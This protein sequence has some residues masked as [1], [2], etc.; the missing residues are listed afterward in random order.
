MKPETTWR[1][2]R[3]DRAADFG[4]CRAAIEAA[5]VPLLGV[6][7]GHQ[8]IAIASGASLERT[9]SLVHGRSSRI[10][11]EGLGLFAGMQ[12]LFNAARYHSFVVRRPLPSAL[13]EI[14][15]TEDGLIMAIAHRTRPQW[16]VQFHPESIATEDGMKILKNF[17]ELN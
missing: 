16:G 14:A 2:G 15:R 1:A 8:G 6:C 4:L 7:L 3:P 10:V 12:P 9:P 17:L 13:E 5:T 11:H